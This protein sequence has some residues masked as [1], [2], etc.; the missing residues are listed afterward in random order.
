M[1]RVCLAYHLYDVSVNKGYVMFCVMYVRGLS[2]TMN[3]I[4]VP[5]HKYMGFT[6]CD[7]K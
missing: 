6:M 3:Y 7:L 4:I 5:V 2:K 1:A